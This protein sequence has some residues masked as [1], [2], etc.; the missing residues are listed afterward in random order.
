LKTIASRIQGMLG[1]SKG[2]V[3][4]TAVDGVQQLRITMKAGH[5]LE[6]IPGGTDSDALAKLGIEPQRIATQAPVSSS[7]PKVRP[8][9]NFGLDLSDALSLSSLD[10]AKVALGKIEDAIS[11]SQT[12]YR[13][14]YWD[15]GKATMVDGVKKPTT[16]SSSTSI[17]QAQ[18]ANYTAALNRLNSG[19][20]ST[21]L[22]GF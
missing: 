14:L 9:G 21:S 2:T 12:A 17:E 19:S 22:I 7:A 18:L 8:G 6:L 15:D 11:M 20:A 3:T 10:S 5:E 4:A 1:A 16:G 13:S